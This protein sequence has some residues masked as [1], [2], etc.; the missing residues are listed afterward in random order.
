MALIQYRTFM[1]F[2]VSAS[3]LVQVHLSDLASYA[4]PAL[5]NLVQRG[6]KLVERLR[7]LKVDRQEFACI[8]F[9]ILFNPGQ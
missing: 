9:L 7:V 3:S 4:G 2:L 5:A 1:P 8:K 6:Q